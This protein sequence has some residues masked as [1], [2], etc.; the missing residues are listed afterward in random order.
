MQS[1]NAVFFWERIARFA[2]RASGPALLAVSSVLAG[3]ACDRADPNA[4]NG[5]ATGGEPFPETLSEW[6]LFTHVRPTLVPNAGVTPY[7]LNTPLFSDYARKYRT[8]WTPDGKAAEWRDRG[9]LEFPV[10]TIISKTFFY[11]ED[12]LAD[13]PEKFAILEPTATQTET[14]G[15]VEDWQNRKADGVRSG[16][17]GMQPAVHNTKPEGFTDTPSSLDE[18]AWLKLETRLLVHSPDGWKALTYIWKPDQNEAEL[19]LVG[20]FV[21]IELERKGAPTLAF[22]YQIPDS[23]QCIACHSFFEPGAEK[24]GEKAEPTMTPIGPTA[25][26]LNRKFPFRN[27]AENQFDR[28]LAQKQLDSAPE[29]SARPRLAVWDDPQTGDEAERARAYLEANCAHCHN[30]RGAAR[31]SGLNLHTYVDDPTAW[32]VCKTPIAAGRGSGG[33]DYDIV[34]GKPAESILV[35]RMDSVDPGI[36]MPEIVKSTIHTEAVT[37]MERWIRNMDARSCDAR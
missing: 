23:N 34:P 10:G 5:A 28:L 29:E 36:M 11:Y 37:L 16:D 26:N 18:R 30:P 25:K 12:E 20:E 19:S 14:P 17:G 4:V 3:A 15:V 1:G 2:G 13:L 24:P 35:Y 32:G 31:T 21:D 27:G 8:I 9:V 7:S 6:R 22:D 33:L